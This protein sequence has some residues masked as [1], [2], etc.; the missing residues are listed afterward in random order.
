MVVSKVCE[1]YRL[2]SDPN[3]DID[4]FPLFLCGSTVLNNENSKA[5]VKHLMVEIKL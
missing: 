3:P 1:L 4:V 2:S 5:I